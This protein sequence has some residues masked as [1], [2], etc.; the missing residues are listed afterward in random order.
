MKADVTRIGAIAHDGGVQNDI[1]LTDLDKSISRF[2]CEIHTIKDKIYLIDCNSS[3]GT[4]L[5]GRRVAAERPVPVRRD[6]H[7]RLGF[8]CTLQL[9]YR[10]KT[11]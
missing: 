1:V 10:Q 9:I 4:Y 11:S 6:S 3:N 2:H 5:D 7:I 8:D